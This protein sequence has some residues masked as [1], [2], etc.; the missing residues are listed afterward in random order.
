MMVGPQLLGELNR[1]L[2]GIVD[3]DRLAVTSAEIFA[4]PS[5]HAT[6]PSLLVKL[7]T[8]SVARLGTEQIAKRF[9]GR[10]P[11]P[12]PLGASDIKDLGAALAAGALTALIGIEHEW[13]SV[14]DGFWID[15]WAAVPALGAAGFALA[16]SAEAAWGL[17]P[18]GS[19][20]LQN[21]SPGEH[22][23]TDRTANPCCCSRRRGRKHCRSCQSRGTRRPGRW[24]GANAARSLG[25]ATNGD[26][27]QGYQLSHDKAK[28]KRLFRDLGVPTPEWR[29]VAPGKDV[30]VAADAVG[31]PCVVKPL[32]RGGGNGVTA[33]IASPDVLNQAERERAPSH[34]RSSSRPSNRATIIG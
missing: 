31:W 3:Q 4:G 2:S 25:M 27:I 11:L 30:R 24:A 8:A 22:P 32:D 19:E 16:A 23:R 7:R 1:V 9:A 34:H 28:A 5:P 14:G 10:I 6:R 20:R 13:G 26:G 18:G 15:C 29:F 21:R 17:A 12:D 33:D